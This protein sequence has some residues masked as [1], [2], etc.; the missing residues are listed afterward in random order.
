MWC[1]IEYLTFLI[2]FF[3]QSRGEKTV[4]N[5][6][7]K[8]SIVVHFFFNFLPNIE[9]E[10]HMDNFVEYHRDLVIHIIF[11]GSFIEQGLFFFSFIFSTMSL[12][13]QCSKSD[14]NNGHQQHISSLCTCMYVQLHL[15]LGLL[16]WG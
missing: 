2:I 6:E 3:F 13:L 15:E 11:A 8:W 16:C 5:T 12:E 10:Q 4:K 7:L 1:A 9:A 14:G